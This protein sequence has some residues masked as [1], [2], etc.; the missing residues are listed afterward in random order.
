[1]REEVARL[2]DQL[3]SSSRRSRIAT[4]PAALGSSRV[5]LPQFSG[6]DLVERLN[7]VAHALNIPFDE[8]SY[9]LD[10]SATLPYIKYRVTLTTTAGYAE[11]RKFL[12]A[13]SAELPHM[14]L[15]SIHCSRPDLL[16]TTL[17]CELAFSAFYSKAVDR[18]D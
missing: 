14:G 18:H 5:L 12:P 6:A 2:S 10:S 3:S 15:D 16:A 4:R 17:R 9:A 7:N 8:A 11:I 1:M 13:L